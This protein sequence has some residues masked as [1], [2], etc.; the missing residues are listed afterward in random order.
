LGK[1]IMPSIASGS[2]NYGFSAPQGRIAAINQ[3]NTVK[4]RASFDQFKGVR[5]QFDVHGLAKEIGRLWVSNPA[6]AKELTHVAKQNLSP[7]RQGDL[8][9]L[10]PQAT[11][12][13]KI[14][15]QKVQRAQNGQQVLKGTGI[16]HDAL[17]DSAKI[18]LRPGRTAAKFAPGPAKIVFATLDAKL[19]YD[20]L[21]G[22]GFSHRAAVSGVSAGIAATA[23]VVGVGAK[24]GAVVGGVVTS[25]SGP[26]AIGGA[27]VGGVAGGAVGGLIDWAFSVSDKAAL[28]AAK[29]VD[30]K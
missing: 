21:R 9:R 27:A 1:S 3:A 29:L 10:I 25:P 19:K 16:A 15:A 22:L 24:A 5:G 30:G 11:N 7:L 28:T 13:A 26:G 17:V 8:F 18:A 4:A 14:A 20:E 23:G 2:F 12:D 6:L